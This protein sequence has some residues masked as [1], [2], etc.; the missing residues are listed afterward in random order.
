MIRAYPV[1]TLY[2]PLM[3]GDLNKKGDGEDVDEA[4]QAAT[5]AVKNFKE[6]M[7]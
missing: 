6:A 3:S 7:K 2:R 4:N 5:D 1:V